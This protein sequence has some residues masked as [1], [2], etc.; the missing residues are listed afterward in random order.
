MSIVR[1]SSEGFTSDVYVYETDDEG[2][3]IHV[4]TRKYSIIAPAFPKLED[5]NFAASF[6]QYKNDMTKWETETE[7]VKIESEYAGQS[8]YCMNIDDC[9]VKLKTLARSGIRV[10]DYVWDVL[11]QL[12]TP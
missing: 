3:M 9:R 4:A 1:W 5:G 11:D 7:L 12:E 8:F 2:F 6:K 10:P